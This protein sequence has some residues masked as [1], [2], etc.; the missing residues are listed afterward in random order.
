MGTQHMSQLQQLDVQPTTAHTTGTTM[1]G[2]PSQGP[3]LVLGNSGPARTT[4]SAFYFPFAAQSQANIGQNMAVNNSNGNNTTTNTQSSPHLFYLSTMSAA[5]DLFKKFVKAASTYDVKKLHYV[6]KPKQRRST[7]LDW[8]HSMADVIFTQP[9]TLTVLQD[10]PVPYQ[11]AP[12][13]QHGTQST[14]Q[15]LPFTQ[16]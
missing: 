16:F 1:M 6:D 8:I 11:C 10:Y 5:S 15:G 13:H 3:Q 2:G 9:A 12:R 7:F 4:T 14:V